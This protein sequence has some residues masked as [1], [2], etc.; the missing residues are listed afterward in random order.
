MFCI[1]CGTCNAEEA[2]FCCQCGKPVGRP[3]GPAPPEAS[4]AAPGELVLPKSSG[5]HYWVIG[6]AVLIIGVIIVL[7]VSNASTRSQ[8]TVAVDSGSS[9]STEGFTPASG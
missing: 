8:N 5:L 3:S 1:H 2:S 9:T 6:C 4:V 7:A